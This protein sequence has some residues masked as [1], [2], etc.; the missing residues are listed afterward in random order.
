[1]ARTRPKPTRCSRSSW[2]RR[3]DR[4]RN[5]SRPRPG[6]SGTLT[7]EVRLRERGPTESVAGSPSPRTR[8]DDELTI[9]VDPHNCFACGSLNEHGVHLD[10]HVDG[11]RCWTELALPDRFQGWDGVAH[12]GVGARVL[13]Q[14]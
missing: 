2:A 13:A 4:A 9:E 3:S 12:G 5:S 6:R 11:D 14:G 8:R 10:L 7:S 1:M